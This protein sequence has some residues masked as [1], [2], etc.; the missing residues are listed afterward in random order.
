[1]YDGILQQAEALIQ[2]IQDKAIDAS[3]GAADEY[4]SAAYGIASKMHSASAADVA[5]A[6]EKARQEAKKMAED[7][8]ARAVAAARHIFSQRIA[9]FA[10]GMHRAVAEMQ[11]HL[12]WLQGG[13]NEANAELDRLQ[14]TAGNGSIPGFMY[15]LMYGGA[16]ASNVASVAQTILQSVQSSLTVFPLPPGHMMGMSI[17]SQYDAHALMKAL[18]GLSG[19]NIELRN[20]AGNLV[21]AWETETGIVQRSVPMPDG[22][23]KTMYRSV[24]D[25]NAWI[26]GEGAN[27]T[28]DEIIAFWGGGHAAPED[29]GYAYNA[30]SFFVD[31]EKLAASG[32]LASDLAITLQVVTDLTGMVDPIGISDGLNAVALYSM[33][34]TTGAAIAVASIAVPFGAEKLLKAVRRAPVG[35]IDNAVHAVQELGQKGVQR[36][37]ELQHASGQALESA[38]ALRKKCMEGPNCFIAGT[39]VVVAAPVIEMIADEA[40]VVSTSTTEFVP[41]DSSRS[42]AVLAA[43][44]FLVGS[45][46]SL[47]RS[48][49]SRQRRKPLAVTAQ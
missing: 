8:K 46:L 1:M 49:E 11:A 15:S 6:A 23:N 44:A 14:T 43:A 33:G 16:S 48:S 39:Q 17:S 41:S 38:Q 42:D 31:E 30:I 24:A 22:S 34:D 32:G 37:G 19:G 10:D 12:A 9:A 26:N 45:G 13:S 25:V 4:Q 18:L 2:Q 7:A 27:A 20:A 35:Q 29:L 36:V 40:L 28:P 5:F 47:R 3:T 21:G